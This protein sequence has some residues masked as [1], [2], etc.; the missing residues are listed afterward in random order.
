MMICVV[1]LVSFDSRDVGGNFAQSH[2]ETLEQV[3]PQIVAFV[4]NSG[5][6][7]SNIGDLPECEPDS[8]FR[9]LLAS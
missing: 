3:V 5:T 1:R 9:Q 7:S 8:N 4:R 6:E 2:R